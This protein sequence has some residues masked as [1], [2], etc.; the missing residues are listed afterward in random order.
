MEL[1][2]VAFIITTVG[3]LIYALMK[4]DDAAKAVTA[5]DK[6]V[7]V[8]GSFADTADVTYNALKTPGITVDELVSIRKGIEK[9]WVNAKSAGDEIKKVLESKEP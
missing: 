3:S 9:T 7:E 5:K 2:T 8:I 1:A 6:C 4:K